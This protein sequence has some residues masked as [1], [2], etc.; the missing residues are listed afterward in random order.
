MCFLLKHKTGHCFVHLDVFDHIDTCSGSVYVL[1]CFW[2][3][4]HL[5][6][7]ESTDGQTDGRYQEHYLPASLSYMVNNEKVYYQCILTP[8]LG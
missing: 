6:S 3:L 4:E 2:V 1:S 7:R 5:F 8:D